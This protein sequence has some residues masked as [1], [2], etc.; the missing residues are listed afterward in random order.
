MTLASKSNN[1]V[2]TIKV[3]RHRYHEFDSANARASPQN[4][5]GQVIVYQ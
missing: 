1:D 4:R 2:Y 3:I 5:E